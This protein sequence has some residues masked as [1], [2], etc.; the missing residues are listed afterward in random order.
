MNPESKKEALNLFTKLKKVAEKSK[1]NKLKLDFILAP[2]A[3]YLDSINTKNKKTLIQLSGQDTFYKSSGSVTGGISQTMMKD[4][5]ADFSIVGHWERRNIFGEANADVVK[6]IRSLLDLK[7]KAIVCVGEQERDEHGEFADILEKQILESLAGVE[8]FELKNI[9]LAYEPV[10]AIGTGGKKVTLEIL[11]QSMVLIQKILH[12]KFGENAKKIKVIY[13]G[14]VD[15]TN[16]LELAQV[17]GVDGF[18]LGRSGLKPD[19]FK[20]MVEKF[21]KK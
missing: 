5:G 17:F 11:E 21:S 8:S 12:K 18:L 15:D 19:V 20:K 7:M 13:G 1:K 4:L 2:P 6:K 16:I 3:I 10:W 9:M 14:S